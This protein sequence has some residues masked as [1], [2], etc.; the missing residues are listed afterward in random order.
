MSPRKVLG[1]GVAGGV[2][3]FVWGVVSWMVL[4]LHRAQLRALPDEERVVEALR[5]AGIER[6]LYLVPGPGDLGWE[7]KARRGPR[8]L[9]AY[10]PTGSPP[11]RMFRPMA[12]AL[13]SSILAGTFSALVLSGSRTQGFPGRILLVLGLGVFAWLLGPA[14]EWIWLPYPAGHALVTFLDAVAGW[15]I[16]GAL[17]TGILKNGSGPRVTSS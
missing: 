5:G 11:N 15:A 10:D 2:A 17:Q 7:E 1:A 9:V 16:V 13:V 6:G 4:P 14:G 8:A 3:L 12:L